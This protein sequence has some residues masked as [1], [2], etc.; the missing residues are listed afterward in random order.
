MN[1]SNQ[2][3]FK[4]KKIVF[5][6][7]T[8]ADFGKLKNI[9]K[10]LSLHDN[11]IIEIFVTGMHMLSKY[12]YT[13]EEVEALGIGNVY[14][15]VNQSMGD[16]MDS[17]LGKTIIGFGDYVR[18]ISPD[19]IIVHG[20]RLEALAGASVGSMNNIITAHIEGGEV[21]G[22]IDEMIRHSVSKLSHLHFVSND[23]ARKRLIKMGESKSSI[24]VI[25]SPDIDIMNSSNLPSISE[26]K[27]YYSIPFKKY[28]IA[29]YHPVTS[30]IDKLDHNVSMFV[31]ALLDSKDNYVVIYPNNDKGSE[32]IL[33]EYLKLEMK[34]NIK[35]FPSMRFEYFLTLLKNTEYIIGN[36]SAG[37]REAPHYGIKSIDIGTRQ[38]NRSKASTIISCSDSRNDISQ[39]MLSINQIERAVTSEFGDGNSASLFCDIVNQN[40]IWSIDIQKYFVDN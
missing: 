14:K 19:M 21:S 34:D 5:L 7:G 12:G 26:V 1:I 22:T 36:S 30:E 17:I 33:R 24:Y 13:C 15:F 37:I 39:A 35:I 4:K 23:Q 2:H 40:E 9:I 31:E 38:K 28:A 11:F 18:E 27:N 8:R 3:N 10:K 25:G 29:A 6:T 16:S 32:T 20:D